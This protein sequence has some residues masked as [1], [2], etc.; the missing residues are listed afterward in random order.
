MVDELC[1]KYDIG[2]CSRSLNPIREEIMWCVVHF[3]VFPIRLSCVVEQ[4]V[5][6]CHVVQMEVGSN[7]MIRR[8]RALHRILL[9]IKQISW[10]ELIY[11]MK[12]DN[13]TA[14][15]HSKPNSQESKQVIF[16]QIG[17]EASELDH[18]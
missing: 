9:Q 14:A 1:I 5:I 17:V 6:H 18:P 8:S 4:Q 13:T 2:P 16:S 12:E 7:H 15:A 3:L 11:M 10:H